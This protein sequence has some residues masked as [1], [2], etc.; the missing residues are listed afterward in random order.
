MLSLVYLINPFVAF[1]TILTKQY[2]KQLVQ[3][4]VAKFL[5]DPV[6][7]KYN[8]QNNKEKQDKQN[9]QKPFDVIYNYL[10]DIHFKFSKKYA[11]VCQYLL[12]ISE[13]ITNTNHSIATPK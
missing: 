1:R 5:I 13:S 12:D 11:F 3:C 6:R 10:W 9:P 4:F 8:N 7:P 2:V